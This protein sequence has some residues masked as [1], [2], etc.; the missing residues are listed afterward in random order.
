MI[1]NAPEFLN[2]IESK[3]RD[4]MMRLSDKYN[5]WCLLV[6]LGIFIVILAINNIYN[7]CL[8]DLNEFPNLS[9]SL[10]MVFT[11]DKSI[12]MFPTYPSFGWYWIGKGKRF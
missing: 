11:I 3:N 10:T 2:E 7:H 5:K 6:I 1:H 4:R 12:P 8:D 9:K